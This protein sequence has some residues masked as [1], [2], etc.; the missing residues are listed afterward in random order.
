M[1]I[2]PQLVVCGRPTKLVERKAPAWVELY[3]G[4]ASHAV[5]KRIDGSRRTLPDMNF[6]MLF[7]LLDGI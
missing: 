6:D 1:R 3:P 5:V 2:V 4:G 7:S